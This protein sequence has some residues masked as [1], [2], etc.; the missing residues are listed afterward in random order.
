MLERQVLYRLNHSLQISNL[1][2]AIKGVAWLHL[3]D[4]NLGLDTEG[5]VSWDHGQ[6][7]CLLDHWPAQREAWFLLW[8]Q[9]G[10]LLQ[11]REPSWPVQ[12]QLYL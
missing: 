4:S 10:P 11:P 5:S 9:L 3:G 12:S 8:L 7:R 1:E 2:M 6:R